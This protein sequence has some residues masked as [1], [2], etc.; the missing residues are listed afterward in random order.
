MRNTPRAITLVPAVEQE[1]TGEGIYQEY[2]EPIV[3]LHASAS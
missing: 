2:S 3:R 1:L